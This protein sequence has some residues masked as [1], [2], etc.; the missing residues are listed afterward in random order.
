MTADTSSDESPTQSAKPTLLRNAEVSPG[1]HADVRVASGRIV[2]V[3]NALISIRGEEVVNA[4]GGAL[5]PGLHDHHLHLTALAAVEMSVACG[6]PNVRDAATLGVALRNRAAALPPGAWVRGIGYH[7]SVAGLLDRHQLDVLTG[8]RPVRVQH[9]GGA[10]W[11]V[12]SAAAAMLGLDTV[13]ID[14]PPGIERDG[15]GRSTGRLWR[16]DGWLRRRLDA[17]GAVEP[18]PDLARVGRRLA[19]YGITGVTDATPDMTPGTLRLLLS[20]VR[21]GRLPQSLLLLGV[22]SLPSDISTD[23]VRLGPRKLLPPDHVPW[24]YDNLLTRI[25]TARGTGPVVPRPVAVHCVTL[26]GLVVA[27]TALEEAGVVPGDRIEHAAVAPP[28]L[29]AQ[30]AALGLRVVTQPGFVA[31]RGDAYRRDADPGDLP[32]LYPY[33]SLLSAG[34]PTVASS[35]APFGS[36]DPWAVLRAARDRLAPDGVPLGPTESVSASTALAGM[37]SP[38]LRPGD[39]L[40]SIGPGAPADLCLLHAPRAV[41]LDEPSADLVRMTFCDGRIVHV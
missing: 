38:P 28:A 16:L 14:A 19:A 18:E 37:L 29:A 23:R 39:A 41:A 40:R 2:A 35:D 13:S 17:V 26:E 30:M 21:D 1:H 20:A 5:L 10:L 9:R 7:E 32:Y 33:A 36:P 24:P 25:R 34:V 8:D 22:D 12:N 31:E 4:R 27:V 11:I 6:P 15:A 3:G